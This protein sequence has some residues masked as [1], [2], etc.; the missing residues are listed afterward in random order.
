MTHTCG[1]N[2]D[3]RQLPGEECKACERE[4][5]ES[6]NDMNMICEH[7]VNEDDCMECGAK[8]DALADR[9]REQQDWTH[10]HD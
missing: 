1:G 10:F 5:Q 3:Y 4:E 7:D 2:D 6:M 8:H 9:H